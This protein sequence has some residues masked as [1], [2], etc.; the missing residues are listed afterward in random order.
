MTC[1]PQ[2]ALLW[3]RTLAGSG[4]KGPNSP[5]FKG[6]QGQK[7]ARDP[8]SHKLWRPYQLAIGADRE[9][10]WTRE[11]PQG[12]RGR[13]GGILT[14]QKHG[15]KLLRDKLASMRVPWGCGFMSQ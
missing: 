3:F 7:G 1:V 15:I 11:G 2:Y 10:Q 4:A 14:R 5:K 6:E 9:S 8:G 12:W 13:G